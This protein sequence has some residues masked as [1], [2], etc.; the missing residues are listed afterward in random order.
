MDPR[1]QYSEVPSGE[2]TVSLDGNAV[3]TDVNTLPHGV[4]PRSG[5]VPQQE[6]PTLEGDFLHKPLEHIEKIGMPFKVHAAVGLS[7]TVLSFFSTSRHA[8]LG[9]S[10]CFNFSRRTYFFLRLLEVRVLS[11]L[12][13]L[14]ENVVFYSAC[15]SMHPESPAC[16]R[17]L[18]FSACPCLCG[19]GIIP[20]LT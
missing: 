9:E 6:Q 16:G 13:L 4:D 18:R 12:A 1:S 19:L 15:I 11:F 17:R 3:P 20:S 2:V 7:I 10:C 5:A 8:R 14:F